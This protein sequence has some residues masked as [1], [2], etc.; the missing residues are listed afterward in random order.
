MRP[1][2]YDEVMAERLEAIYSATRRLTFSKN[3]AME[4]VGGKSRLMKLVGAN[5]IHAEKPTD[6]QNGRWHCN[7][8]DVLRYAVDPFF[9]EKKR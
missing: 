9:K 8:S 4:I 3:T 7:A 6:A 1:R 2:T 5:K